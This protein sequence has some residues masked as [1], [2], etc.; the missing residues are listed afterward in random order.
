MLL[1]PKWGDAAGTANRSSFE[2]SGKDVT[3]AVSA[4]LFSVDTRHESS[5]SAR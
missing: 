2:R 5:G 3:L 1:C 4:Y